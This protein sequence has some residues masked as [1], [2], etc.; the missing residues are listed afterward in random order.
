MC[1]VN[2]CKKMLLAR[3][4]GNSRSA[5][6]TYQQVVCTLGRAEREVA[7]STVKTHETCIQSNSILELV[8]CAWRAACDRQR[9]L[10]HPR[11]T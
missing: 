10:Q 8:P 3:E 4:A 11:D 7:G 9:Q 6:H 1:I 2:V 5:Y